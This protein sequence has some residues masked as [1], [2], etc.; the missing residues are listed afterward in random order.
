MISHTELNKF[1]I[2]KVVWQHI[3]GKVVDYNICFLRSSSQN[4]KVKER[5]IKIGLRLRKLSQ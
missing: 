3:E 2:C 5:I 1:P 4:V